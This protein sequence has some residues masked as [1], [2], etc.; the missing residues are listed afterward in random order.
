M[1][2]SPIYIPTEGVGGF[3]FLHTLWRFYFRWIPLSFF[4]KL[5]S[6]SVFL[7]VCFL[8][9]KMGRIELGLLL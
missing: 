5:P 3:L 1:V 9:C 2:V 4:T 8:T 7:E 6:K